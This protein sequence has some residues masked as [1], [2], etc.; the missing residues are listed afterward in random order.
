[1]MKWI[2]VALALVLSACSSTPQKTYYQLPAL[3][4]PTQ[5]SGR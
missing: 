1:M 5:V 4:A 3:G 2:P